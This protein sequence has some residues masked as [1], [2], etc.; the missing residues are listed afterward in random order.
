MPDVQEQLESLRQKLLD[1]TMRNRLLNY[2]ESKART[3][4]VIDELP[5]EVYDIL[6][7]REKAMQF[8]PDPEGGGNDTQAE[9]RHDAQDPNPDPGDG[10]TKEEESVLWELPQPD[11]GVASQHQDQFLQTIYQG[12]MLQKRLFY[13]YR[14]AKEVFEE[15]G[16]TVLFLALAYLKWRE[17]PNT[18][19]RRAPILLVPVELSRKGPG[20]PFRLNWTGEEIHGNISLCEK[21]SND[22]NVLLPYF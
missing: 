14:K 12:D 10:H 7:L 20:R 17:Q 9:R 4:R 16:Y 3:I 6:V 8:K 18:D 21:L 2:R 22:F 15:Q 13:V 5:Q 1:L 19:P 11:A